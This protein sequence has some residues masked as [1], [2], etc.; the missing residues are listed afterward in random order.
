MAIY[1]IFF[2]PSFTVSALVAFFRDTAEPNIA[3]D[4]GSTEY[5]EMVCNFAAGISYSIR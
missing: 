3:P 2:T 4:S 1:T 5:K